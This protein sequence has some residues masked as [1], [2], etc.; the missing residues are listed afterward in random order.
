MVLHTGDIIHYESATHRH[1]SIWD[2]KL[3]KLLLNVCFY[4]FAGTYQTDA[5]SQIL[6]P[7]RLPEQR[8]INFVRPGSA[9]L[10]TV[11][12][13]YVVFVYFIYVRCVVCT[14]YKIAYHVPGGRTSFLPLR[15]LSSAHFCLNRC[16]LTS[17]DLGLTRYKLVNPLGKAE[18]KNGVETASFRGSERNFNFVILGSVYVHD[19]TTV[20]YR[21]SNLQLVRHH[22]IDA[23][24]RFLHTSWWWYYSSQECKT[25][26][27]KTSRRSEGR[28]PLLAYGNYGNTPPSP[29]ERHNLLYWHSSSSSVSPW[30]V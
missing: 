7:P 21:C 18:L 3:Q 5:P 13:A 25:P 8:A 1:V 22:T 2:C 10:P 9:Q 27:R 11:D 19:Q 15:L 17:D 14:T 28:C 26:P 24:S 20:V 16:R 29:Q 30:L 12:T 6:K 4:A 23:I